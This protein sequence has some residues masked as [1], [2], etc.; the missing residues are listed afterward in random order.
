M[1]GGSVEP[2]ERLVDAVAREVSEE[3]GLSV[4]VGA[5]VE[6]IEILEPPYHY[7]I[8]DYACVPLSGTLRAGDDASE[9][10]LVPL[11]TLAAYSIT[12]DVVRVI[13]RAVGLP[14]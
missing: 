12:D 10:A 11:D 7:V 4:Q 1:P 9:V 8:L 2:G 5:L 6:I 13:R 14:V 3:T